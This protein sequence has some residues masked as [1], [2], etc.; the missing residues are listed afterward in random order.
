MARSGSWH[1]NRTPIPLNLITMT[2]RH[3]MRG[4][5][6]LAAAYALA[7]QAILLAVGPLGVVKAEFGGLPICSGLGSGLGSGHSGGPPGPLGHARDCLGTCLGCSYGSPACHL[8]GPV[9]RYAPGAAQI[10]IVVF[11]EA[12]PFHVGVLAAHR[13]RG[14]PLA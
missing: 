13:T 14:P 4:F 5:V 7:L 12:P 6:A 10:V 3:D 1:S 11:A 2:L 8:P 9:T